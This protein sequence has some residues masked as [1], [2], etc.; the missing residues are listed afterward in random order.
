MLTRYRSKRKPS[1][2]RYHAWRKKRLYEKARLPAL[3][4]I[5]PRSIRILKG[6]GYT[7]KVRALQVDTANVYHPGEKTFKVVKILSVLE[8]PANPNYVRRNILNKGAI[9]ET[10]IG[11]ARV[12]NRPSQ[13]GFVNAVLITE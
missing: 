12:T 7:R 8:N 6:R 2:G 3:T 13:E 10:E 9:I 4:R 5:G 11:R 1:G